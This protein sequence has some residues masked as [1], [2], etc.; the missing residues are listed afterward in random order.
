M[1][2]TIARRAGSPPW[3]N[4]RSACQTGLDVNCPFKARL[5]SS[6][7][8][9]YP[10]SGIFVMFSLSLSG[11]RNELIKLFGPSSGPESII[12]SNAKLFASNP[13][14]VLGH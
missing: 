11:Q 10:R 7:P 3:L 12:W 4:W 1:Q 2:A 9:P 13:R 8:L 5:L 6:T 14:A